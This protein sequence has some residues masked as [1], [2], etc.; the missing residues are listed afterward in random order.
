M[1]S[2]LGTDCPRA[3]TKGHRQRLH[4]PPWDQFDSSKTCCHWYLQ[5]LNWSNQAASDQ[6]SFLGSAGILLE[7]PRLQ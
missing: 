5:L 3:K 7:D 6:M 4:T 2:F 1:A